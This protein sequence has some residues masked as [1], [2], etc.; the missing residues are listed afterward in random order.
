MSYGRK[1]YYIWRENSGRIYF[2]GDDVPCPDGRL[3]W[4]PE[5]ALAQFISH[6]V[7]RDQLTEWLE[8]GKLLEGNI[9]HS[10]LRVETIGQRWKC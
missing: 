2:T 6:I 10:D 3:T 9:V 7:A 8:R 4:L 5:D 1:P